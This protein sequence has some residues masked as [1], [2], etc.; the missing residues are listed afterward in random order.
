MDRALGDLEPPGKL[1]RSHL[2]IDL[3]EEQYLYEPVGAHGDGRIIIEKKPLNQSTRWFSTQPVLNSTV[4]DSLSARG[5]A[6]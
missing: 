4:F 5:V 2:T 6:S 3:K 1:S